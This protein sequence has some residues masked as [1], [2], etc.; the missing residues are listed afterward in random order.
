MS[1][2]YGNLL[3]HFPELKIRIDL[4]EGENKSDS[5]TIIGI[6][7]DD[8]MQGI[9][10]KYVSKGNSA[11]EIQDCA[12]LYV[13]EPYIEKL[14]YGMFFIHPKEHI[15]MRIVKRIAYDYAGGYTI[16]QVERVTG[17][18]QLHTGKLNV[19]EATFA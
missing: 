7:F 10:A 15:L 1:G 2:V 19:K 4:W 18:N 14:K 5:V 16:W 9:R 3:N 8:D 17:T 12:H 11:M 6:L 13:G